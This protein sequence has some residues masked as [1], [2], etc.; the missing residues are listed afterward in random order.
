MVKNFFLYYDLLLILRGTA[1][2]S[3]NF[4]R[5]SSLGESLYNKNLYMNMGPD[6]KY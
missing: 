3:K 2:N 4:H 5:I 1:H 6:L